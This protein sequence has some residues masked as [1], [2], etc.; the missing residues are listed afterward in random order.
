M[1]DFNLPHLPECLDDFRQAAPKLRFDPAKY[2][3]HLAEYDLSEE[4]QLTLMRVVWDFMVM[5]ADAGYEIDSV[6]LAAA[7]AKPAQDGTAHEDKPTDTEER[8]P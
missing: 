3:H 2:A 4:Q 5:M 7:E 8:S 1:D 6:S